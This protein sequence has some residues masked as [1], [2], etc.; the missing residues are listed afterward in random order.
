MSWSAMEVV[1]VSGQNSSTAHAQ[2]AGSRSAA[3]WSDELTGLPNRAM[4]G[5][6]LEARTGPRARPGQRIGLCSLDL[7]GFRQ[8]NALLGFGAGDRFLAAVATRLRSVLEPGGHL[9]ARTGGD[10]FAVL[11]DYKD[12]SYTDHNVA[13]GAGNSN[14]AGAGNGNGGG[15]AGAA[16]A[17]AALAES[18][19]PQGAEGPP[20]RGSAGRPMVERV[21]ERVLS[22]LRDPLRVDGRD[23]TVTASI[24]AVEALAAASAPE[25]LLR[26]ADLALYWAK[27]EGRDRWTLFDAERAGADVARYR[28]AADLPA[29][30]ESGQFYCEYQPIV[31]LADGAVTGVEALVRWRH[32]RF[33]IVPPDR[34]ISLAEDSGLIVE[35]GRRILSEAC[36]AAATW[37]DAPGQPAP[38]VSVNVAVRQCRD[39]RL[40]GHVLSALAE[41][42]LA[43]QRL[44]LEITESALLPGDDAAQA[45][46]R[47]LADK[48]VA[49]AVDDFGTGYSNLSHLRRL[50]VH[51]LKIDGT[52]VAGLASG[53]G[54]GT[55]A[56]AGPGSMGPCGADEQIIATVTALG[57]A[58][59]LT[60]T[61]EG[62]ETAGQLETVRRLGVDTGQGWLFSRALPAAGIRDLLARGAPLAA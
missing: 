36:Q 52:F 6:W 23:L 19:L 8:I 22:A 46:L 18:V 44:R 33:G 17:A 16:A 32:P 29:A 55:G 40:M 53:M 31:S 13:A 30:V 39:P 57:H 59:G 47:A 21:A 15:V 4:L 27:G 25:D 9:L 34:F 48:G 28:L 1:A 7:D 45:T 35:L 42:G 38:P 3:P 43:P 61:A 20:R 50:P 54:G 49:I 60:V 5:R 41:S 12:H 26:A 11:V 10:E 37:P 14:G 58:L 62:V 2:A 24:G 56:A 51:I